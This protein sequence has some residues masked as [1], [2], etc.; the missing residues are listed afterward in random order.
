LSVE[1]L[2]RQI[3]GRAGETDVYEVTAAGHKVAPSESVEIR[4]V[5][6]SGTTDV[7]IEVSAF[8]ERCVFAVLCKLGVIAESILGPQFAAVRAC[9][10][11]G[12]CR[13]HA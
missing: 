3:H 10:F 2:I 6:A 13:I 1:G 7:I 12:W 5:V 4:S 11:F 8:P 9:P